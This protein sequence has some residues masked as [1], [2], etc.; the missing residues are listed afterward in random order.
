[1]DDELVAMEVVAILPGKCLVSGDHK[2]Y[3]ARMYT[4][5]KVAENKEGV[6]L[7]GHMGFRGEGDNLVGT[8]WRIT[9]RSTL[10]S[11]FVFTACERGV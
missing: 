10:D 4:W 8:M 2:P 1:M 3:P 9:R 6:T 7:A 11:R 5:E